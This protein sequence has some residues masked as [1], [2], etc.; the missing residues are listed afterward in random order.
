MK[1]IALW[2]LVAVFFMHCGSMFVWGQS[3]LPIYEIPKTYIQFE[4][5]EHDFGAVKPGD[6]VKY[7]FVFKNTG[8]NPLLITSAKGSCGCII[9]SYPPDP[10]RPGKKGVIEVEFDS[11]GKTGLQTKTVTI[12]AN[13][14]PNPTRLTIKADVSYYNT[15]KESYN[16]ANEIPKTYIQ[17]EEMEHDFGAV[18]PGDKVKYTFVFKNTGKNPLLI[19]SAKGS[20]GCIIASYPPDPIRPGKKGVIEVEFDSKGKT[21]LQTKTVTVNANTYP[22]PT[23][24]TIKADV[25]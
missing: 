2:L 17:F 22:N 6:K 14:Y 12:N 7:T 23:R 11:K 10:I 16:S 3:S 19:T 15:T 24:L 20:C 25:F 5:M 8:K 13:T 18:K 1:R 21:G 4:E 9:A